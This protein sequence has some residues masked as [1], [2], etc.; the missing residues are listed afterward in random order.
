MHFYL[1][2]FISSD[3]MSIF[4]TSM[5][6]CTSRTKAPAYRLARHGITANDYG[7][8]FGMSLSSLAAPACAKSC[9]R[10]AGTAVA[11]NKAQGTTL[12]KYPA[13]QS[14]SNHSILNSKYISYSNSHLCTRSV[15]YAGP[16]ASASPI[17]MAGF[18]G[19]VR[20]AGGGMSISWRLHDN[21][22]TFSVRS[23]MGIGHACTN[24][25]CSLDTLGADLPHEFSEQ[26]VLSPHFSDY[27][28]MPCGHQTGPL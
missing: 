20:L 4:I 5:H 24:F 12:V 2:G 10:L 15:A 1:K 26:L 23:K 28:P 7:E 16:A 13:A 8:I 3:F 21:G 22:V 19:P 14:A 6:W 18:S 27:R 17:T 25:I 9:P 11:G